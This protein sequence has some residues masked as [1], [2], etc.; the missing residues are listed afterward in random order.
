[1]YGVLIADDEPLM[2]ASL[3]VMISKVEGFEVLYSVG[4]GEQAVEI[5]KNNKIDIVFMDIMMPGESGIE[6]SKKIYTIN[7]STTIFIVSS[8]NSFDFAIEALKT[9]VKEYIS[10]PVSF[11]Q[12]EKLLS[13]YKDENQNVKSEIEGNKYDS[14]LLIIKEKITKKCIMKFLR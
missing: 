4:S 12:I 3:K 6:S 7:P 14:L 5:C 1:M 2:R 11:S 10:K 8:Y 13:N 9:K